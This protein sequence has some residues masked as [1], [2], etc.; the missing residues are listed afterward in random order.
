M[1]DAEKAARF[2]IG[3]TIAAAIALAVLIALGVWQLERL[4]W[5]EGLLAHVAALQTARPQPLG[6]V[7]DALAQG[8]DADFTRVTL[9]CPGLGAA[10][11]LE[12]YGL[13]DGQA[14]VRLIS[15]CA[16]DSAGYR[17]VLVD[18]GYVGDTISARPPIDPADRTPVALTGVLRKPDK[19][20][21]VTPKNQVAAN[22]WYSRDVAAMAARLQAPEPAPV[23]LFA[24][25]SSNPE[26]KA[27]V[28]APLPN[29]IPNRHF[30][31]ALTW[32]GLAGALGAVYAAVLL[33]RR[34]T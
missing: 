23:F 26:W 10:P 9:T 13:R 5:K 2:P 11:Y 29:E 17:T 20:S 12:L 14:G 1:T 21:F 32:F 33:R 25:T 6:P 24:E 27:L 34:K 3:L 28:P 18:R 31:Y 16:V 7:L 15:A 4:K 22:H 30:E 8:R 19:A